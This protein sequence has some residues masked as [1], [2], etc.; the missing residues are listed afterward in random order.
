MLPITHQGS[1]DRT[2]VE[3]ADLWW[4]AGSLSVANNR[5]YM[6]D[7]DL[8]ELAGHNSTPLAKHLAPL[9]VTLV[10]EPGTWVVAT[11]GVLIVGVNTVETRR[12]VH[13]IGVDASYAINVLPAMYDIRLEVIPLCDSPATPALSVSVAGHIN[14]GLDIWARDCRLPGAKAGDLLDFF[15]AGAYGSSMASNHCMRGDFAEVTVG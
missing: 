11:A 1:G 14:E 5:L 10:C 7:V 12:Q 2:R 15:P 9:D 3:T 6:D 13:W 8:G 4:N